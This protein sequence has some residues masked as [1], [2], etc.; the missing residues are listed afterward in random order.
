MKISVGLCVVFCSVV[1]VAAQ[2]MTPA[3]T[4]HIEAAQKAQAQQDCA[5]A[6]A[7]YAAA[8]RLL[9]TNGELRTNQGIALYCN[10]QF[11]DAVPV[12]Q[13]ALQLNPRLAVPHL[14]LGLS[15]FHLSNTA[16]AIRELE[17]AVRMMPADINGKLWL[18]YAYLANHRHEDAIAQFN[19]VIADR[20]GNIDARYALGQAYFEFGRSKVRQL[21]ALAPHGRGIKLLVMEERALQDGTVAEN[22]NVRVGWQSTQEE[23]LYREASGA[24]KNARAALQMVLDEAPDSDRAH[25]I[26]GEIFSLQ[27]NNEAAIREYRIVLQKNPAL[28]GVRLALANCLMQMS[29]FRDA[30]A[31]LIKEQ[32]IQPGFGDVWA[33]TGKVQLALGEDQDALKSLQ[34]ALA[35]PDHSPETLVLMG[36]TL[37]RLG[38]A[39]SA[40]PILE[41]ALR[42]GADPS[43]TNYFL[44]R[45]YRFTGDRMA[46]TKALQAYQRTSRDAAE[47]QEALALTVG[48]KDVR[49]GMTAQEEHDA[50]IMPAQEPH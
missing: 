42:D 15:A 34:H 50:S 27:R 13:K 1:S 8:V 37:L 14:F 29:Q 46:M 44:A 33:S 12:F 47:R 17:T 7:E 48:P 32:E 9:P 24:E 5:T 25:E 23:Q 16:L 6:A 43:T 28:P 26:Q 3:L 10:H 39:K 41:Q 36:K 38:E 22:A 4:R 40:V 2:N 30:L 18:G 11:T 21:Q 19:A 35:L 45:A 49:A 31:V 20:P